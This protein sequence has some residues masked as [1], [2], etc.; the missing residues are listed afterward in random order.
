MEASG[1][2]TVILMVD[3]D[4][5][6][7]F[8]VREAL[9]EKGFGNDFHLCANGEELME[10]LLGRDSAMEA[11]K[12]PMPGVILLDLNMPKTDGRQVLSQI[13][14]N[15][16]LCHIPVIVLTTSSDPRDV[17]FCYKAGAEAYIQ[18]SQSFEGLS[19]ALTKTIGIWT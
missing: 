18:K 11:D 17:D 7:F 4:P 6:D 8:I 1:N 10:Y 15:E 13:K 9:R 12:G 14:A 3:D 19:A 16:A 2:G 5:D